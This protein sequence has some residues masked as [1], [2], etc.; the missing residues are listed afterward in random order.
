MV[1]FE[2]D[3]NRT[4]QIAKCWECSYPGKT[5]ILLQHRSSIY[6]RRPDDVSSRQT[7]G[8]VILSLDG[9][10]DSVQHVRVLCFHLPSGQGRRGRL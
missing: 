1:N 8:L 5:Q 9:W 6:S 3:I 2:Y 10:M 7:K 4:K